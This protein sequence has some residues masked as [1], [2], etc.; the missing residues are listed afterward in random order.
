MIISISLSITINISITTTPPL[1]TVGT[2]EVIL[3]DKILQ[4][5]GCEPPR[6]GT[7]QR[8]CFPLSVLRC[9]ATGKV[10]P[11][12]TSEVPLLVSEE[13]REAGLGKRHP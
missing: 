3:K 2:E 4:L 9:T 10:F 6:A 8:R 1:G 13:A 5:S 12:R 7:V 11:R